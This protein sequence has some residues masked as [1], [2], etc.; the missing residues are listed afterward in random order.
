MYFRARKI[1][2]FLRVRFSCG[3]EDG[4]VDTGPMQGVFRKGYR[5][6]K[7]IHFPEIML[8]L[9]VVPDLAG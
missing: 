7:T 6:R 2:F 3:R 1:V 5:S 9:P 8:F 4:S